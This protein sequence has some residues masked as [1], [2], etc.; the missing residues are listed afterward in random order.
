MVRHVSRLQHVI[1]LA[2]S[3]LACYDLHGESLTLVLETAVG[4]TNQW[5]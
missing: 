5:C 1:T 2:E 4:V 3:I